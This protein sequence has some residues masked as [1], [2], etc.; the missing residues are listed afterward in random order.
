VHLAFFEDLGYE[1]IAGIAECPTGTVKSRMFH[2]R[3]SLKRCLSGLNPDANSHD[4]IREY[5]HT[6]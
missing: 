1:E 6:P 5:K 4:K 3:E 2:A